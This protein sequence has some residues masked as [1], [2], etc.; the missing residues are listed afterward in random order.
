MGGVRIGGAMGK[1][2][3]EPRRERGTGFASETRERGK[4]RS[5]R[6]KGGPRTVRKEEEGTFIRLNGGTKGVNKETQDLKIGNHKEVEEKDGE[7]EYLLMPR[8]GLGKTA[9]GS[10]IRHGRPD[11]AATA[12]RW[13]TIDRKTGDKGDE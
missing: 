7:F 4:K 13:M 9:Y 10:T 8:K 6:S 12:A 5:E 1:K 3:D 11:A 2:E